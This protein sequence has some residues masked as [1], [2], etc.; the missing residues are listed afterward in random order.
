M[1]IDEKL[2]SLVIYIAVLCLLRVIV[3]PEK[4]KPLAYL[5]SFFIFGSGKERVVKRISK[6]RASCLPTTTTTSSSSGP[7]APSWLSGTSAPLAS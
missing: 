1:R 3:E 5:L 4:I 7:R 6:L 2:C